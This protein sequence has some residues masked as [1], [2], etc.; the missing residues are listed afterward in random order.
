[1]KTS[2]KTFALACL[3][4][5]IASNGGAVLA[6][7]CTPNHKIDQLVTPGKL[8]VAIY[9]YPPFSVTGDV[10]G[11]GDGEIL[12][13]IAKSACLTLVPLV[14]DPAATI[15]YV[16]SG[17]AD[18]AGGDWYRT[19]ERAKVLG[20]SYPTYLDQMGIYSKDGISTVAAMVGKQVG[21]V[22]GFL[23]VTDL[24]KLLGTNLHLYPNPV[25]LA[26]DLSVGRIQVGVDSYGTGAYAQK[27][28][29]YAGIIIKVAEPDPRVRASAEAAQATL[30]YTKGNTTL[31]AAL[32][33]DIEAMHKDGF[34][35]KALSSF[36]LDPSGAT[37]GAPRVVQ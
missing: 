2:I 35:G 5:A 4:G 11:G 13:S 29:G 21:T 36:G 31:G 19:A 23:W 27:K 7:S 32:D 25:A 1:V 26:Q 17:K 18:I 12:K 9:E 10:I 22:S 28:G 16:I 24:Q 14:V 8:T 33:A 30:L 6:Q 3:V 15:Q 20:L 34:I 37:V